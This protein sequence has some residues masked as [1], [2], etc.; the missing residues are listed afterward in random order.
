MNNPRKRVCFYFESCE[1]CPKSKIDNYLTGPFDACRDIYCRVLEKNVYE[2][3]KWKD[4]PPVPDTCPL[5]ENDQK[6]EKIE[7]PDDYVVPYHPV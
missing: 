6:I 3:V 7:E 5:I 2:S 1:E 4:N